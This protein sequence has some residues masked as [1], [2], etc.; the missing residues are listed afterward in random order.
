MPSVRAN[1]FVCA[2]DPND[3]RLYVN[4]LPFQQA[5]V[6]VFRSDDVCSVDPSKWPE[7][8]A[9]WAARVAA[10][11]DAAGL[12][13][14]AARHRLAERLF[15]LAGDCGADLEHWGFDPSPA[16]RADRLRAIEPVDDADLLVPSP[17]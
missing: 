13:D 11:D 1:E 5:D 4:V 7:V 10:A 12:Y 2:R 6:C 15:E 16:E 14:S 9:Y 3:G 17:A 8:L